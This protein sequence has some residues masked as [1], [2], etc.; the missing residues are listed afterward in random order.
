MTTST[1]PAVPTRQRLP[2]VVPLI[3]VVFGLGAI[4]G[5]NLAGRYADKRPVTTFITATAG[6]VVLMGLLVPFSA[7][8]YAMFVLMFLLGIAGMGIPPVGTG[9]AVRCAHGAPTLAAAVSVSA[10]NGGTAI[11]TWFGA[12]A[13]ESTLGVLGPLTIA[14]IMGVLG[15]LTLPVLAQTRATSQQDAEASL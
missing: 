12:S 1:T 7:N 2:F 5:T 13:L 9:L 6:T 3:F 14:I 10:F 15:L 8:A 4:I 11:G